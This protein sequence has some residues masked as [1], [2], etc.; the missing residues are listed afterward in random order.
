MLIAESGYIATL[1]RHKPKRHYTASNSSEH[2]WSFN[3]DG[4]NHIAK[5]SLDIYTK[6]LCQNEV[7]VLKSLLKSLIQ[8]D[9]IIQNAVEKN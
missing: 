1:A 8:P 4:D 6:R 3:A 7:R 2:C 9:K 5:N